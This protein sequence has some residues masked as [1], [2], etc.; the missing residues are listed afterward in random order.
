MDFSMRM[1]LLLAQ[2]S[3]LTRV[4]SL[5]FPDLPDDFIYFR[6]C[7][8]DGDNQLLEMSGH[9]LQ[10]G[11]ESLYFSLQRCRIIYIYTVC[12]RGFPK[13]FSGMFR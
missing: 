2:S 9:G 13:G 8:S 5:L 12:L 1:E 7:R 3:V 4:I 11:L 10:A 6:I